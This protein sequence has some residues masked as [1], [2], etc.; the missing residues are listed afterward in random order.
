MTTQKPGNT[1]P[2]STYAPW[3]GHWISAPSADAATRPVTELGGVSPRAGFSRTLFQRTVTIDQLPQ[4]ALA[5]LTADSRYELR[6]NGAVVGRGPVRSQPRRLH[7]DEYDLAPWLCLGENTLTVLV[8][9]YGRATSFWQPAAASGILGTDAALVFEARL[10]DNLIESDDQWRAWRSPAWTLAPEAGLH[11]VPVEILDARLL[12]EN[13][14]TTPTDLAWST[15]EVVRVDHPGGQGRST[16]PVDPYGAPLPRPVGALGGDVVSPA[17]MALVLSDSSAA[18]EPSEMPPSPV[19][20]VR[21]H[22]AENPQG[23]TVPYQDTVALPSLDS[24]GPCR[25]DFDFG[26]VI[27]GL[28]RLELSAPAGTQFDLL[29]AE[30]AQRPD[31][32]PQFTAPRTGAR[33]IARGQGDVFE[34][35]EINGFRYAHLVITPAPGAPADV[36]V[37]IGPLTVREQLQQW[38]GEADFACDDPEITALYWAGRR[39]V[40]LN[41][42]DSFTDCPTREQRAWVGD[43]VVHQQVHLTTNADWRPA[44]WYVDLANSPRP[45]G[46]LPMSVVGEI[47]AGGGFTIPDWSLHWAHG[48]YLLHRYTG[49]RDRTLGLLPTVARILRW[50]VPFVDDRGTLS[51]LPEWNLVDWSSV[52]T[53]HRTSIVTG[54]WARGLREF[55]ELATECGETGSAR[56]AHDLLTAASAGFEDFWD[57]DRG[58]YVDRIVSGQRQPES[59]QAAGAVAI[60]SGLAPRERW[61]D[62]ATKIIDPERVVTRSWIGGADGG[63]DPE[64]MADEASGTLRADWDVQRQIVRAQPF[65]SYVVHDAVAAAGLAGDL[66]DQLRL[67]TSFLATGYD[68]FGECWGWGTPV[69]GWSCAPTRDLIAYILGVTPAT[70]G[71][72]R[73]RIAPALGPLRHMRGTVP[74]PF[75]PLKVKIEE[76]FIWLDSP[77]EVELVHCDG[78]PELLPP[79]NHH[80]PL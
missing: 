80:R 44:A 55:A 71:F 79:G 77:V 56:W 3:S 1:H 33:Y 14:A 28:T 6:V 49:D 12:P 15:A 78:S 73:A 26:R 65:F 54:L 51:D 75:G 63:Y 74:T 23:L 59:S 20:V 17:T 21:E 29:Y 42:L 36:P 9:Y 61:A 41:S 43:G 62:L 57:A 35:Q 32:G 48:V 39:T 10:G 2:S 4:Q 31:S 19:D 46:L 18:S 58:L 13:W 40:A 30:W 8:T 37:V 69:H 70:S 24:G 25:F 22:L 52:F 38:S 11:G 67:W 45:D 53:S 64:K 50:F 7:Y 34:A 68:T 76:G 60:V 66:V 47:E 72:T 27:C 5:R 16:P